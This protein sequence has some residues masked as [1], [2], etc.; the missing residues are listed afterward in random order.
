M[1]HSS[2]QDFIIDHEIIGFFDKAITLKSG[3]KSHFYV[4]WRRAT[5]D[6][7]LLNELT[8]YIGAFLKE[9]KVDF[10]SIIG[11]PEGASKTAILTAFKLASQ[12]PNF[13]LGSHVIPM[14]RS[15]QKLHGSPEDRYFIGQPKG[16]T[17]VLEDTIT[18]GMS[19]E[20]F[21]AS[22]LEAGIDVVGCIGLTD[23]MEVRND[24]RSVAQF[25]QER[26]SGRVTYYKMSE[27]TQLLPRAIQKL[28]PPK[29]IIASLQ[30]EFEEFGVEK[31]R[32][33]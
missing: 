8:D 3:R 12:A 7:F 33:D 20:Q 2:F 28:S 17:I 11:V 21:I 24:G 14:G 5:N 9:R 27:A 26:F 15:K 13:D 16:R 22:L 6:A 25:I 4:N 29:E 32:I 1:V 30:A 31:L 23:R 10:D 18:T 19:L